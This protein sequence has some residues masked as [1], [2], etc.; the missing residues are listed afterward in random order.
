MSR[1]LILDLFCCQGGAG[2]GYYRAGFDVVGIDLFPQPRYPFR[3]Y[4]AD[5]ILTLK[6]LLEIK[7]R[8]GRVEYSA[9]HAGYRQ[10]RRHGI[11]TCRACKD[12]NTAKA[13]AYNRAR[14]AA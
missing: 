5:A 9:V 14:R 12:A 3:F 11:E 8:Y 13:N 1:P 4:Q 2:M 10:H 7:E 6:S